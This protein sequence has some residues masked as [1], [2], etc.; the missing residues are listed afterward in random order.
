MGKDNGETAMR[1]GPRKLIEDALSGR[2]T[3]LEGS[4]ETEAFYKMVYSFF[5]LPPEL[6]EKLE[7]DE[8]LESGCY[9]IKN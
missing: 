8:L 4:K 6:L 7:I 2:V 1:Q 5:N 3:L 9:N